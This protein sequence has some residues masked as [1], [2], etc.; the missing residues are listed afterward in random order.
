MEEYL[1]GNR[2]YWQKGYFAP[3][4]ESWVFRMWGQVLQYELPKTK[5]SKLRMLDFG[6][7]QG[8][9]LS[10][11]EKLGF[12]V[13]GVDISGGDIEICKKQ[14]P[15]IE[16]N[17]KLI[18]P[19]P[20]E[21]DLW[22]GGG[23]DLVTAIQSLYYYSDNDFQKRLAS[24]YNQMNAGG[25]FYATMI[26]TDSYYYDYSTPYKDGLRSVSLK[27]ERVTVDNHYINFT[28]SREHLLERFSMFK[29]VNVGFYDGIVREDE[30]RYFHWTYVG[31]KEE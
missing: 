15:K 18:D 4:V 6:C 21:D 17:F 23:F 20:N 3:N 19:V 24:I 8:A 13:F 27:T 31:K 12:D 2:D 28:K 25:V 16:A 30:G 14:M 11:F 9:A 26:G 22:Y 29:K 1:A 7:G 10:F 5:N